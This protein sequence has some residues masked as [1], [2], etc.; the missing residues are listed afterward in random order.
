MIEAITC[1]RNCG[2]RIAMLMVIREYIRLENEITYDNAP[3]FLESLDLLTPREVE[4]HP[5][6][7]HL[8]AII[9][10]NLLEFEKSEEIM[11]VLAKKLKACTTTEAFLLL[12]E[13]YGATG[14]IHMLKNQEDFGE[15][16]EKALHYLPEGSNFHNRNRL[17]TRDNHCFVLPD[18]GVGAKERMERAMHKG[19]PWVQRFL[20]G[21]MSGKEHLFS[22][23]GAYLSGE[24]K[25]AKQHAYRALYK[26]K[27]YA[28]HDLVCSSYLLLG[29]I[30]LM[31]GDFGEMSRQIQELE[32]YAKLCGNPAVNEIR[33]TALGWYYVKLCDDK[34]IPKS[35]FTA[36]DTSRPMWTYGR[37]QIVYG[38]HLIHTGDYA[39][40]VGMLEYPKGPFFIQGVTPD[41]ITLHIMLAIGYYYLDHLDEAVKSLWTAY[42][43]SYNNGLITL[44]VEGGRYILPLMQALRQQKRF[45][46]R[47][48]WIGRIEEGAKSY[49]ERVS[50]VRSAYRKI[51]PEPLQK[52]NPL[53]KRERV[54]LQSLSQG[55]TREE[56]AAAHY[57]SVNTVKSVIRSIY[58][59]LDA[60]NRAEAVS[61]AIAKGYIKGYLSE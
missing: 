3:F 52:D 35:I 24:M 17:S 30:G 51:H 8:R 1:Y 21:S 26:A 58:N 7:E 11:E 33:D 2:D 54:V 10:L 57:I 48:E 18:N 45:P 38:V 49:I 44:F 27:A 13:V 22:A 36:N 40:L 15:L 56:I 29:R 50:A 47:D 39:R 20:L 34:W 32:S 12:G 46:F 59:K 14:T 60:A 31:E 53:S 43:M 61:I 5:V 28:Q 19:M 23:E 41:R 55:L 9:Y 25:E 6:A 16:Y 4:E 37:S 42:E